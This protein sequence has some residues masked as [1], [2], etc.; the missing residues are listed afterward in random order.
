MEPFLSDRSLGQNSSAH[1]GYPELSPGEISVESKGGTVQPTGGSNEYIVDFNSRLSIY[2]GL[3][4][5]AEL[6]NSEAALVFNSVR[7]SKYKEPKDRVYL[8]NNEPGTSDSDAGKYVSL[9]EYFAFHAGELSDVRRESRKILNDFHMKLETPEGTRNTS[10]WADKFTFIEPD[11][12]ESKIVRS[13]V[14][15]RFRLL[16]NI[17]PLLHNTGPYPNHPLRAFMRIEGIRIDIPT[18][19]IEFA[20]E[21]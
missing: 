6:Y 21:K 4:F 19:D 13:S 11:A 8:R 7:L 20:R 17:G 1:N 15:Q 16:G 5:P 14:I 3:G 10:D 2:V 9:S 12:D 18:I